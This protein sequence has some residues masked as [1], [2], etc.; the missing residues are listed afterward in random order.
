MIWSISMVHEVIFDNVYYLTWI[1]EDNNIYFKN[2]VMCIKIGFSALFAVV[3]GWFKSPSK[4]VT[5][6]T[7]KITQGIQIKCSLPLKHTH[8]P[9]PILF[10]SLLLKLKIRWISFT[11][12]IVGF[13]WSVGELEWLQTALIDIVK[14]SYQEHFFFF[15]FTALT[16]SV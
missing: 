11:R 4:I 9:S 12:Q 8:S 10:C 13:Q 6:L 3:L 5:L 16:C 7:L 1:V 2:A 14:T 15:F